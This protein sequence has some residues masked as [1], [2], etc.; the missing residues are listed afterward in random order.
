M[1]THSSEG[2]PNT[3]HHDESVSIVPYQ[4]DYGARKEGIYCFLFYKPLV[5]FPKNIGVLFDFKKFMILASRN[6]LGST[7]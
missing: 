3:V 4:I 2:N 5:R 1:E 7:I 6:K